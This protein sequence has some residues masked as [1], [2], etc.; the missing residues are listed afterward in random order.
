MA[1]SGAA[2]QAMQGATGQRARA[3]SPAYS[4]GFD[5]LMAIIC[6]AI[7]FGLYIDGW[8]H[9]HGQVDESF[10]TPWHALLYGA[11]GAAG[12]AL[13]ITHFRNVN[14]GYRWTRALPAGYALSLVGFFAFGLGGVFDLI[15][16]ET[17]GFEEGIDALISPSHLYLA[18]SGLLILTG[19]IR[20]VWQRTS[21]NSCRSL[22]P[23]I[24]SFACITSVFT[25]FN[26]F[27]AIGGDMILLTG[28]EPRAR[29][30]L[31]AAG[32][33][34]LIV[35]SNILLG[36]VLFMTRRWRLPLGSIAFLFVINSLLMTWYRLGEAQ[37]FI[38]AGSAL[39]VGLICELLYYRFGFDDA[40]RLRFFACFMPFAFSLGAVLCVEYL[41]VNVW[42]RG[43]LWWEIHMWLGAPV[44]AGAFGYG[45]SMLLRPPS[46]A[47]S[48]NMP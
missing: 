3:E 7:V 11:V 29:D 13:I 26:G 44:L 12:L 33:M 31:D 5:W 27:V 19:P 47:P 23:A 39:V 14:R 1:V 4:L 9:N 45:L 34:A 38:F 22:T 6:C 25:F 32:I 40:R 48:A 46:A 43:G 42:G 35:Q 18:L 8:A 36:A 41:G 10:F 20:S 21:D 17:F 30:T 16:H 24:L 28:A 37:E 2:G 15:W